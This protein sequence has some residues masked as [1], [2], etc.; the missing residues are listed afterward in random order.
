MRAQVELISLKCV[1]AEEKWRKSV[2]SLLSHIS[3]PYNV[4]PIHAMRFKGMV[5]IA[6]QS[7]TKLNMLMPSKGAMEGEKT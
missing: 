3:L 5:E 6:S 4:P 2:P 1:R 7:S